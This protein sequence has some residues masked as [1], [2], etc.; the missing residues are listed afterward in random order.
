MAAM[1]S[2]DNRLKLTVGKAQRNAYNLITDEDLKI[3]KSTLLKYRNNGSKIINTRKQILKVQILV[4][5]RG[6][7]VLWR[8]K[9]WKMKNRK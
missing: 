7:Q 5:L 8:N 6:Y 1:W 4:L 3:L 9:I 2:Q